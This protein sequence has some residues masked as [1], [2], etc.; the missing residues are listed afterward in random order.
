[1]NV[2]YKMLLGCACL[3]LPWSVMA[4]ERKNFIAP[5][6]DYIKVSGYVGQRMDDCFEGRIIAQD[7]D[8]LVNPFRTK[9]EDHRWQME[10]WG[11]W[12]QGAIAAYRYTGNSE[13][14][15]KIKKSVEDMISTQTPEGYIGNYAPEYQL[16]NW[17]V[18]G[19]KY[20]LL[21]LLKWYDLTKDEK[22][23]E[24]ASKEMDYLLSQVG[25]GKVN[26]VE[27][28]NYH[29]MASCSILEPTMYLY[30]A[31][32]NQQY[33]DFAKYIVEQIES[34]NGSKLISKALAG[35][36][37]AER[38][39]YPGAD[40]WFSPQ[41]GQKAYEMMSCYIGLLEYYKETHNQ[42]CLNAVLKTVDNII[43]NEINVAGSGSSFECWY[44]GKKHQ[45]QPTYHTMETCVTF[46]WMQLCNKL[47]T[48][49]G[50]SKYA[51]QMEFSM[52]NALMASLKGDGSQIS[53]YSPLEGQHTAGEEQCGMHINCCNA[54]GPRAFMMIPDYAMKVQNSDV[55]I[56]FYGRVDAYFKM[57]KQEI[58]V[59]QESEYPKT[60]NSMISFDMKKQ[61]DFTVYLR[62]PEWSKVNKVT[63]N[64]EVIANVTPGKYVPLRRIWKRGDRISIEFDMRG[65][66]VDRDQH[67]AILRGPIVLAR[68]T[69][70]N[71]GFVDETCEIFDK[72][73]Y[74]DLQ[75]VVP[76]FSWLSF[77]L[78]TTL[79]TDLE[80]SY[81]R[82]VS[83]CD[84]ASAGDTWAYKDRYRVW[85]P[86]TLNVR[87]GVYKTYNY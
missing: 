29:G 25:P 59:L 74:V 6:I 78:K 62:I 61:A 12:V 1:M 16:T 41:Q 47:L 45:V 80:R 83:F 71:D 54:N 22:T 35:E 44:F 72:D 66:V 49:T 85:L 3:V 21:G 60:G 19:R 15:D 76:T 13:L 18:W 53:K 48:L 4:Q 2:Y 79:G 43:E 82:T 23:L 30:R 69:R 68:D 17:D 39:P 36:N 11:K 57:G 58:H 33:F 51:D 84:F 26:I 70:F 28:G 75:Q 27:T 56:N 50:D 32:K 8:H 37:V 34:A 64:D 87:K 67:K 73:G 40:N 65:R 10:F 7:V 31:T 63:V 77:R 81:E 9:A 55:Y 14:Y 46:T 86:Q 5:N 20:T 52:Y 38:F 42:D 24:A